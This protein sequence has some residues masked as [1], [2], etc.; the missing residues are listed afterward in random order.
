MKRYD[1]KISERIGS[2][3]NV[4]FA[5]MYFQGSI[6]KANLEVSGKWIKFFSDGKKSIFQFEEYSIKEIRDESNNRVSVPDVLK[7]STG[8]FTFYFK[9][10][11][12]IEIEYI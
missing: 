8:I 9:D 12:I 4:N 11:S 10:K 6:L 7:T 3:I 2:P 1:N 5:S